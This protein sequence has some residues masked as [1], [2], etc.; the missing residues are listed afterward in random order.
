MGVSTRLAF[1]RPLIPIAADHPPTGDGWLHEPK[2]D[3]FR[4][5]VVKDGSDV[6]FYSRG[7]AEFT[8]RLP[9]IRRPFAELPT[10]SAIL[11]GELCLIDP[12]GAAHFWR[13]MVEMRTRW[14]DESVL[15][16]YVFDIL[17]QD[18]VDLRNLSL[19]QRK[20]DLARLCR[21]ARIPFMRQVETFPDGALL[22]EHCN[23]FGFEGLVSKRLS[24]HYVSGPSRNWTKSKCPNWKRD[25]AESHRLFETPKKPEPTERERA[26]KEKRAEL[27]RTRDRLLG[28]T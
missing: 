10:D 22:L 21:G 12:T 18:C 7:G 14:P 27:A 13:L 19:T 25:N 3:G 15:M 5:Q 11:D 16:F 23:N 17:H 28:P 4:F 6:R 24:S 8:T 1:I 20:R 26:L 2:W 9:Q